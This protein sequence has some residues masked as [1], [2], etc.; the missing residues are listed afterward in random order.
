MKTLFASLVLAIAAAL[1]AAAADPPARLEL[2]IKTLDGK[3]F[4]LAEHKGRW[5]ILNFWATWCSPCIKEL[6]E[7]S[8]F[9]AAH[10]NVRAIGLA[11]EDTEVAEIKAFLAKH[12]V[13]FPIAQV[14]TFDPPKSLET[15]RGLPTTYLVAPDGSIAKKFM[16]PIDETMLRDAMGIKD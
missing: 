4:D 6:P 7:L 14:D 8:R 16:G 13:S 15:P 11:Y 9:V 10:K 5:V 12:P 2:S 3:T 1:P